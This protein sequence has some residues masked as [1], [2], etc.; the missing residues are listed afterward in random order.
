MLVGASLGRA[1]VRSAGTL[2]QVEPGAP[3]FTPLAICRRLGQV[4]A[5][6]TTDQ[7]NQYLMIDSTVVRAHQQAATEK[8]ATD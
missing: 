3:A 5:A 4:F 2:W 6:L 8:G 1:R 7:D